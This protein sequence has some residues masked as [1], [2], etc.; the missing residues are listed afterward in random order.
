MVLSIISFLYMTPVLITITNSFMGEK[1]IEGKYTAETSLLDENGNAYKM[2]FVE[3]GFIPD[4]VT[5]NQYAGLLLTRPAYLLL[6]W[7]SVKITVPVLL[8]QLL[9]SVLSAYA[10]VIMS[11]K[12]KDIL[13]FVYIL[14]ML[15]PLQVILVPNYIMANFLHLSESCLAI[16]L[17]GIFST[18]GAFLL[19]QHMKTIPGAYREAA[20]VDGAN[21][22]YVF[23]HIILPM[24]RGGIAALAMLTFVEYWNVVDQ[25]VVF[26]KESYKEPLSVFLS[27]MGTGG[28]G[29]IFSASGFYMLPAVLLFLYGQEYLIKG[30]RLS[31]IRE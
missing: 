31:G 7:N 14:V 5:L 25:A 13:F 30:I 4:Q 10:F 17:P 2:H 8:G 12:H 3:M 22:L 28:R 15:L 23:V 21:E 29:L 26:I 1:E 20:K 27:R 24:A 18:F 9:V 16:I 6:F 19:R 11:S